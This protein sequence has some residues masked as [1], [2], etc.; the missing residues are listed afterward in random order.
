MI[1]RY[2]LKKMALRDNCR[3]RL[4][5]DLLFWT[6]DSLAFIYRVPRCIANYLSIIWMF[7]KDTP[8]VHFPFLHDYVSQTCA[9]CAR[10][11]AS[12]SRTL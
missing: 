9:S 11:L 7:I 2:R 10:N 12:E 5:S 6:N 4:K 1:N 3:Q 8:S